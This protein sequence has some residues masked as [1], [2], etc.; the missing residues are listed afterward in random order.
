MKFFIFRNRSDQASYSGLEFGA[1]I[2]SP[3]LSPIDCEHKVLLEEY[4]WGNRKSGKKH[5]FHCSGLNYF[6][7]SVIIEYLAASCN[8]KCIYK[9]CKIIGREDESFFQFWLLN[10]VNCVD[11]SKSKTQNVHLLPGKLGSI[12]E[13]QFNLEMWDGS[14]LFIDSRDDFNNWFVTE[15]FAL[16]WRKNK[17]SGALFSEKLHAG[18]LRCLIPEMIA[19]EF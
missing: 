7:S 2:K 8:G 10:A 19:W 11:F 9:P 12:A 4:I 1:A 6:A 15:K 17:F 16:E 5:L 3:L 13:P 18:G 14:D